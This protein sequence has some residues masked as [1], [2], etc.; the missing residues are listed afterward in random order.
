AMTLA[1]V[2]GEDGFQVLATDVATVSV[3]TGQRASYDGALLEQIPVRFR[4]R[5]TRKTSAGFEID[6]ALRR[7]VRFEQHNLMDDV[8][9]RTPRHHVIFC[10]NTLVYFDRPTQA[11]V[12]TKLTQCLVPRGFLFLGHSES[13]S[14]M[15]LPYDAVGPSTFRKR[16]EL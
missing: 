9:P 8:Y 7:R 10:R 4:S 3:H 15:N 11:S 2:L 6:G 1:D 12:L 14:G 5:F 16:S 13:M